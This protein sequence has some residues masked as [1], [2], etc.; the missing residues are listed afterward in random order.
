MKNLYDRI[1][2]RLGFPT[3]KLNKKQKLKVSFGSSA[4]LLYLLQKV[5]VQQKIKLKSSIQLRDK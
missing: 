1:V 5:K 2:S 3:N 4:G